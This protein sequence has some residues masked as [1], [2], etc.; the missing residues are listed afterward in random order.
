MSRFPFYY[1]GAAPVVESTVISTIEHSTHPVNAMM[2][3]DL[4]GDKLKKVPTDWFGPGGP[5]VEVT[6]GI[7]RGVNIGPRI[8]NKWKR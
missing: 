7:K 4:L 5:K 1:G 2:V 8:P 3:D 6:T